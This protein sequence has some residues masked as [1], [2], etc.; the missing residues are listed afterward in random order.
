[1]SE[2]KR[3]SY[4]SFYMLI[5]LII[6]GIG[7]IIKF[8]IEVNKRKM[9][10]ECLLSVGAFGAVNYPAYLLADAGMMG[11]KIFFIIL[12]VTFIAFCVY[13]GTEFSK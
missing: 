2:N 9:W 4:T 1:M 6:T 3:G 12:L 7:I 13:W 5:L 8:L 10:K 11:F